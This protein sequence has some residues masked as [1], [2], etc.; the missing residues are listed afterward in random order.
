[1][2]VGNRGHNKHG[3]DIEHQAKVDWC[4][5]VNIHIFFIKII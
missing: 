4:Y 2:P 1:L 5:C 3:H